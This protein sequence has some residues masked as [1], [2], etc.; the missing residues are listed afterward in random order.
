M[1]DSPWFWGL[2][3]SSMAWVALTAMDHKFGRRQQQVE[4]AFKAR[5]LREIAQPAGA[6]VTPAPADEMDF[7]VDYSAPQRTIISLGPLRWPALAVMCV[8]AITLVRS[9]MTKS[10]TAQR[11]SRSGEPDE[12]SP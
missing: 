12:G 4:G 6:P 5:I 3:F 8:S 1:T 7:D 9:R 11:E 10:Q 2:M